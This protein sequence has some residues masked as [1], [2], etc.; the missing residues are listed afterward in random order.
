MAPSWSSTATSSSSSATAAGVDSSDSGRMRTTSTL[1]I[2][3]AR[4]SDAGNYTCAARNAKSSSVTVFV[5]EQG[6]TQASME[7]RS[8]SGN[9]LRAS[10]LW[11]IGSIKIINLLI[12]RI[13][14]R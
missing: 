12:S 10:L 9:M 2:T 14:P 11:C 6:D 5:S 1:T 4:H 13:V 3:Q 8:N 7:R